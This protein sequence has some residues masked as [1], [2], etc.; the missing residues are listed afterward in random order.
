MEFNLHF[1]KETLAM[2]VNCALN[3]CGQGQKQEDEPGGLNRK[4][5]EMG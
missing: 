2:V 4:S 1:S 5:D 3:E